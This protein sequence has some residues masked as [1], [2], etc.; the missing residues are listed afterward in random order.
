MGIN[1]KFIT[2]TNISTKSYDSSRYNPS[3]HLYFIWSSV[4][5][6][7]L[8]MPRKKLKYI[9]IIAQYI[10]TYFY[11]TKEVSQI[12]SNLTMCNVFWNFLFCYFLFYSVLIFKNCYLPF[13]ELILRTTLL[14]N[15]LFEKRC[16]NL[17]CQLWLSIFFVCST[18]ITFEAVI[19]LS[20]HPT[21]ILD[22]LDFV[23]FK[24]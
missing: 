24:A 11:K 7:F 8:I 23:F 10:Q 13:I 18:T 14:E 15:L 20:H 3:T 2:K 16:S 5:Q 22:Q 1:R 9:C 19:P 6:T 4:F 12:N 21:H 17:R